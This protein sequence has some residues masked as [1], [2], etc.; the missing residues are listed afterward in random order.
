MSV[1]RVESEQMIVRTVVQAARTTKLQSPRDTSL[2]ESG[3]HARFPS[4]PALVPQR[5][6][7]NAYPIA[8]VRVQRVSVRI[9]S[10]RT[11]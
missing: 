6:P 5:K 4:S 11:S 1:V 9:G 2:A 3:M 8:V 7:L 10:Y